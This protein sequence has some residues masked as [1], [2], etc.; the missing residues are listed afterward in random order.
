MANYV[1]SCLVNA[2]RTVQYQQKNRNLCTPSV[3]PTMDLQLLR[4]LSN[5]V[6]TGTS[7]QIALAVTTISKIY[8]QRLVKSARDLKTEKNNCDDGPLLPENILEAYQQRVKAGVDPG[9]FMSTNVAM[10]RGAIRMPSFHVLDLKKNIRST[11]QA[12]IDCDAVEN[13]HSE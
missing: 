13:N 7:S 4:P 1:A 8:A 9:F 6:A 12:Q 3:P 2:S 5:F 10:I 11:N